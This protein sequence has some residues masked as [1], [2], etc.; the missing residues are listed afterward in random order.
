M[1]M[2]LSLAAMLL[3]AMVVATGDRPV[4]AAD[5]DVPS[6]KK[7]GDKE[8]EW[9]TEVGTAV[10][11]AARSKPKD[12]ELDTYKIEPVKDKKDRKDLKITMNWKGAITK[13]KVKSDITIHMDTSKEKE[14][15][16][17]NIE[18]KDDNKVSLSKPDTAKIQ[19]LIKEFNRDV[20]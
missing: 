4:Y 13:T 15:E 6:F 12:V 2:T 9:V 7:R 20:K 16:V 3:A 19:A 11:K 10:V 14:W 1:K 5:D 17:L 18:Y 8:K